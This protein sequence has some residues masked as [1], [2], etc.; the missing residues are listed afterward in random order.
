MQNQMGRDGVNKLGLADKGSV[1]ELEATDAEEDLVNEYRE[2][3]EKSV[4][5]KMRLLK[6][7]N[8]ICGVRESNE[9]GVMDSDPFQLRP[10]IDRVMEGEGRII[11]TG[12]LIKKHA[13]KQQTRFRE[14]RNFVQG[15]NSSGKELHRVR[16][17]KFKAKKGRKPKNKKSP[18]DGGDVIL[19]SQIKSCNKQ[20]ERKSC[21]EEARE[22][23]RRGIELGLIREQD[24]QKA[25]EI[26]KE[27][28][29]RDRMAK[30]M[31][32]VVEGVGHERSG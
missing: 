7:V 16:R 2:T 4:L 22:D 25:W 23:M 8:E 10:I 28:E 3:G 19:D 30:A 11:K 26:F 6:S 12:K 31:T 29:G 15:M 20:V 14:W 17:E 24:G 18:L 21:N 27:W 5:E 1:P 13:E 9:G 32:K